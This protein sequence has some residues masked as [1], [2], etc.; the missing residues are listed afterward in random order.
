MIITLLIIIA[1]LVSVL[2]RV[3]FALVVT[4]RELKQQKIICENLKTWQ[5]KWRSQ[6]GR[7]IRQMMARFSSIARLSAMAK[8]E[9]VLSII[10]D[11]LCNGREFADLSIVGQWF[12]ESKYKEIYKMLGYGTLSDWIKSLEGWE[13]RRNYEGYPTVLMRKKSE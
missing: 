2:G 11:S 13:I 5:P 1:I 12:S 6:D 4:K 9:D 3:T 10:F 8:A 7:S